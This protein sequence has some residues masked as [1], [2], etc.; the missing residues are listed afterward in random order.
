MVNLDKLK[1]SLTSHEG[2]RNKPYTD[3]SGKIT[4]GVGRNLTDNGVSDNEIQL[5]LSND[6]AVSIQECENQTWW[7]S[8]SGDDVRSRAIIEM[9]FN[10]G[11]GGLLGF[12]QAIAALTAG[13]FSTAADQF[14]QSKW[15]NQVGQRAVIL[16]EMIRTGEDYS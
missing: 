11:I 13:D 10:I 16:T 3:T 15:A 7:S 12:H 14:M 8:I 1:V 2:Y 6:I 4:I 9:V 5:L